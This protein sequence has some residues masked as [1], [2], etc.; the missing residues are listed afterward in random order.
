[1]KKIA[2]IT[3]A[4]GGIGLATAKTL[5]KAGYLVVL[6]GIEDDAA[7]VALKQLKDEN[8]E[9]EYYHFDVTNEEEVTKN[10]TAIGENTA[11]STYWSTMPVA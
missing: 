11:I 1:M 7:Q 5:G 3:G 4:T 6:N 8:I 10:V 9:A 2:L